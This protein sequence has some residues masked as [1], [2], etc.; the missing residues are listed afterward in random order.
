MHLPLQL[1]E[2]QI[3]N[4]VAILLHYDGSI[5]LSVPENSAVERVVSRMEIAYRSTVFKVLSDLFNR[6]LD[7]LRPA[8][9]NIY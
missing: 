4:I 6:V 8:H 7:S 5:V 3:R 2:L 1:H 9:I